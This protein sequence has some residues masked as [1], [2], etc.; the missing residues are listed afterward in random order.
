M[1]KELI[2]ERFCKKLD[3]YNKNAVI[4]RHMAEYLVKMVDFSN[5]SSNGEI[6]ILELGCG[7]GLLTELVIKQI[8][9]YREYVALDIVPECRFYIEKIDSG[10]RFVSSDIDKFINDSDDTKYDLII[11][12]ATF[13]WLDDMPYVVEKLT[14]KLK[15]NGQ[16][17]FSTF[18]TE[19][20][21]EIKEILGITLNYI[22]KNELSR[23]LARFNPVIKEEIKKMFFNAPIDILRHIQSTGV[24]AISTAVWTKSDLMNFEKE[25][26]LVSKNNPELTYHP[27][28]VVLKV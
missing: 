2:R 7:T 27:M 1:N 23:I 3:S 13:Q 18:G 11:S 12:N 4:Q 14:T 25:Y 21:K 9:G 15:P 16:L 17:V 20:F 24:N 10:I 6:S 26:N 8:S 19:N 28:Y 5:I 22:S